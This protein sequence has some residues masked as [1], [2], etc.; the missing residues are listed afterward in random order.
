MYLHY[1]KLALPALQEDML[2]LSWERS[3]DPWRYEAGLRILEK[4]SSEKRYKSAERLASEGLLYYTHDPS[5]LSYYLEAL[6]WLKKDRVFY[7]HFPNYLAQLDY[8]NAHPFWIDRP[9]Q[10]EAQLWKAVVDYRNNRAGHVEHFEKLFYE[11]N[12]QSFH[13]RVYL[14]IID[15]PALKARF[16]DWQ[17][18]LFHAKHLGTHKQYA[19][20][21]AEYL[22]VAEKMPFTLLPSVWH[23]RSVRDVARAFYYSNQTHAGIEVLTAISN[24]TTGAAHAAAQEWIG[25]MYSKQGNFKSSYQSFQSAFHTRPSD[26]ML[27]LSFD[28]AFSLSH[29]SGVRAMM[30]HGRRMHH[31]RYF[32][33]IFERYSSEAVRTRNWQFL[34]Q[35]RT[36]VNLYGAPYDKARLAV[37]SSEAVRSGATTLP[38]GVTKG[39]LRRDLEA[40][41]SQTESSFY[42]HLAAHMIGKNAHQSYRLEPPGAPPPTLPN[43]YTRH[44]CDAMIGGANQFGLFSEAYRWVRKCETHFQTTELI[45]YARS[46]SVLQ[47]Y[48]FSIRTMD[49]AR[50]R[51]DFAIGERSARLIYPLGYQEYIDPIAEQHAFPAVLFYST[52]REE[53]YFAPDARSHAGAV[54]LAQIIPPTARAVA[55]RMRINT[56]DLTVPYH[57]LALG[58]F[59]IRELLDSHSQRTVFALAAYNAGPR[60]V[61]Q[62][63]QKGRGLSLLLVH[64]S[65]HI[66]ETRHYIRKIMTSNLNY[67]RLYQ[68]SPDYTVVRAFYPDLG[69]F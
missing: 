28:A 23:V 22:V 31:K 24:A 36:I 20:A 41:R 9:R 66:F 29:R 6:Y 13:S 43:T 4:L 69:T 65:F 26:R 33:D 68:R 44:L 39:Q 27:W 46:F 61:R 52:V 42:A 64:E 14:Y 53:S 62:W 67:N 51:N 25:R 5:Y 37:L 55:Q 60:R 47:K 8:E 45:A 56:P 49:I 30:Q 35:L 58:G 11:Q 2:L 54:G 34:W 19:R 10:S 57:N 15:E 21:A 17:L 7:G 50:R 18:A 12:A 38:R 16:A 1:K 59:H 48:N 3:T 63:R 40:A 32:S